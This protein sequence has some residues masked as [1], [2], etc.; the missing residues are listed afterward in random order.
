MRV[1]RAV[2][3]NPEPLR[4][5]S[6]APDIS[7]LRVQALAAFYQPKSGHPLFVGE[8]AFLREAY[9]RFSM[10]TIACQRQQ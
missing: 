9:A 7:S 10:S 2:P 6:I 5:G 8:I 3:S 1:G 4:V